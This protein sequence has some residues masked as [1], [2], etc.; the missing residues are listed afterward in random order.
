MRCGCASPAPRPP[1]AGGT[2]YAAPR[3][4]RAG[5]TCYAAARPPRV[6]PGRAPR[7]TTPRYV[8][9]A[10]EGRAT[11]R[12]LP[13]F[14]TQRGKEGTGDRKECQEAPPISLSIGHLIHR[15]PCASAA[16]RLCVKK[17]ASMPHAARSLER[18]NASPHCTAS[19]LCLPPFVLE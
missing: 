12:P 15:T 10:P 14:L 13:A 3:P 2:C 17:S 18:F 16:L 9:P 4:P 6:P 19:I 5:G 7:L 11:F 1:C 8:P